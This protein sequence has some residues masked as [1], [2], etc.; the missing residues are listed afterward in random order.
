MSAPTYYETY[1]GKALA[2]TR[3]GY[4]RAPRTNLPNG[5]FVVYD[6]RFHAIMGPKPTIEVIASND[7]EPFAHEA[8]VYIPS[9][10][11]IFIT[12]NHIKS[13][14][15]KHI[16]ISK[17]Q[18]QGS[19]W[20]VEPIEPGVVLANGGVNYRDGVLFCEQGSLTE[21]GGLTYMSPTPPYKTESIISN[22]HGRWFNSVNDV[23]I[24]SDGSIW[25]TDPAYGYEQGIRPVPQLVNQTYRFDPK[26]GDIRAMDDSIT[27]PNGLCFDPEQKTLYITDTCGVRGDT[28]VSGVYDPSKHASI[29]AFD[30]IERHGS[31]FLANKRLFAHADT[32]IPDGIKCDRIG[33]VYSGCGDGVNVWSP[34]G[35]LIGKVFVPGGCANFCFGKDGEMFM[36]NENKMYRAQLDPGLRGDLLGI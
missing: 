16:Q 28:H 24:H 15:T 4:F 32:G 7:K 26:T 19:E 34:G 6:E 14:G 30:I 2:A 8:G 29:Y 1:D 25:F 21:P 5:G 33:N 18:K 36:L 13:N 10:G 9:T 22:Y 12:S 20:V 17:V 23:V 3:H 35:T 27:K 31:P 11:D